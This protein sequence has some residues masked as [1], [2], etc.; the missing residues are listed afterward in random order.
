MNQ[1]R[2]LLHIIW[3]CILSALLIVFMLLSM[4][5]VL[6]L[7]WQ[8]PSW[9]LSPHLTA[10]T[11]ETAEGSRTDYVNANG[12]LTVAL[13][14]NYATVI[15]DLDTNG[16]WTFLQYL[17]NKGKP[18]VRALGNS[19][20]RREYNS[21]GQWTRTDYLDA[22]LNPVKCAHGYASVC[23]TYNDIG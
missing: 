9:K 3:I 15:K 20:T 12:A 10:R 17:D 14:T 4:N 23:L 22:G 21:E 5:S 19:A 1:V 2:S 6:P 16:N 8:F 11:E 13:D 18:A 7:R